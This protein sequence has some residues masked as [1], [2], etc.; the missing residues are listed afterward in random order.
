M[1]SRVRAPSAAGIEASSTDVRRAVEELKQQV[2]ALRKELKNG[3]DCRAAGFLPGA[4][5]DHDHE[6]M[7]PDMVPG[8]VPESFVSEKQEIENQ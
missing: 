5:H 6:Y 2:D 8:K 4:D 1:E 3:Q 7:V